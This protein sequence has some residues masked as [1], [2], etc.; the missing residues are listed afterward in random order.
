MSCSAM[1]RFT[2][3]TIVSGEV[4]YGLQTTLSL[5]GAVTLWFTVN[6]VKSGAVIML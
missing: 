5:S 1:I 2:V 4:V 3:N 6:I